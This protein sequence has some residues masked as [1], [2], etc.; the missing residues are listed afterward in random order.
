MIDKINKYAFYVAP[1][2][3]IFLFSLIIHEIK[4]DREAHASKIKNEIFHD[5]TLRDRNRTAE[6]IKEIEDDKEFNDS[7][8]YDVGIHYGVF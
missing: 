6:I 7:N 8:I 2:V 3:I 4:R 1:V 5:F